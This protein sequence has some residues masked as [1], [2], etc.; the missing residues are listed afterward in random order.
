ML[1]L[2]TGSNLPSNDDAPQAAQEYLQGLGYQVNGVSVLYDENIAGAFI[3]QIDCDKDPTTDMAN[4]I[5]SGSAQRKRIIRLWSDAQTFLNK[6]EATPP[7][8]PTNT[9]VYTALH[10]ALRLIEQIGRELWT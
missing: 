1:Y 5:Y 4:F 9:D 6:V 3:Y 7:T 2:V 8:V 10:S